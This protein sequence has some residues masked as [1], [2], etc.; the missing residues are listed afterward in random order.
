MG[1]HKHSKIKCFLNISCEAEIH[2]IPK[3]R[4]EW[5]S[6]LQNKYVET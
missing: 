6:L 2:K 5:I 1:K 3:Q 4:D